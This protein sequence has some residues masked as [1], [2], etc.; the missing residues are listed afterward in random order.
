MFAQK[1]MGSIFAPLLLSA[2]I[3]NESM[4]FCNANIPPLEG[5]AAQQ[6]LKQAQLIRSHLLTQPPWL[7]KKIY[8]M[9]K[10]TYFWNINYHF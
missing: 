3:Q 6:K 1:H 5:N 9:Q 2:G 8:E 7:Q 10:N 4:Q